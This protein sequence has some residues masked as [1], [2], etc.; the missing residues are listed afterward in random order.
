[1]RAHFMANLNYKLNYGYAMGKYDALTR[2]LLNQKEEQLTLTFDEIE[3]IL[4][5]ELPSAP[6]TYNAWWSN[7]G[8]QHART[9]LDA[10]Y[11]TFSVKPGRQVSFK[12]IHSNNATNSSIKLA[13]KE[14]RLEPNFGQ[15]DYSQEWFYEGNIQRK[16]ANYL[17]DNEGYTIVNDP[18]LDIHH[19]GPDIEA[20]RDSKTLLVEVKGYPSIRYVRDAPG[21]KTGEIKPTKPRLQAYHWFGD[22]LLKVLRMKCNMPGCEVALGFPEYQIYTKLLDELKQVTET[23]NIRAYLVNEDGL[24]KE[25]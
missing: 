16:I 24:I 20:T 14:P 8:H 15:Y 4:N 11:S 21:G 3:K 1:M 6:R 25:C 19:Q 10:N 7:S 17:R 18:T 9:W 12:K 22:A 2:Y 23:F 5:F 13:E